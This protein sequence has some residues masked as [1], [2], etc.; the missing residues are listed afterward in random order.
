M[1]DTRFDGSDWLFR[2]RPWTADDAA[3]RLAATGGAS[4]VPPPSA[5]PIA[6]PRAAQLRAMEAESQRLRAA[7]ETKERQDRMAAELKVL[8]AERAQLQ[9][10]LARKERKAKGFAGRIRFGSAFSVRH[11]QRPDTAA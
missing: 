1:M 4:P 3:R 7:V 10:N 11:T 5:A 6:D 2:A 8:D 9:A